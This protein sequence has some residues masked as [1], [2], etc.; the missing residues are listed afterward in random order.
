MIEPQQ[1]EKQISKTLSNHN[2]RSCI[3]KTDHSL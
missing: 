2:L 3:T 1:Q